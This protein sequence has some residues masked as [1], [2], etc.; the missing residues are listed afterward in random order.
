METTAKVVCCPAQSMDPIP[1]GS[2]DLVVTSPPYPMVEMW[3]GVFAAQDEGIG[4][5][6]SRGDGAAAFDLMHRLL[7]GAWA[8][9]ARVLKAGGIA[10][11]N[12]GDATRTI[13]GDFQLYSNHS[14]ILGSF[15]GKG[16]VALPDILWRKQTNAPTKF[17][18]SGMLPVGAYVTYEHEYVLVL[19]KGSR[20]TFASAAEKLRRRQSAFF[21]EERNVWFSDVWL[22][23]KGAGQGLV[24]A[25]ARERS[26]AFPFELAYRLICMFSIKGDVVL[27]PFA[28]TGTTLAAA[29]ATGRS[30]IG[31]ELDG[32]LVP[33]V[34]DYLQS[35]AESAN[36]YNRE[37]LD[38][39]VEWARSR[40]AGK[41]PL[42][43]TNRH[44]GFP[45]MT[46]QEQDLL[47]SDVTAVSGWSPDGT[48]TAR[49][50]EEPQPD[51]VQQGALGAPPA[52]T[53]R[54]DSPPLSTQTHLPL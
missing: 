26:A 12:I 22:D 50:S 39:H 28:G 35:V 54:Q 19:R 47:I 30:S 23:I 16:F 9:C 34:Q 38:R 49:Y 40:V 45:V 24:A 41:G 14:R 11:I 1:D 46:R 37:R 21:W 48:L 2:V 32:T 3:D 31:V 17:M 27:D 42:K 51:C 18:G 25:A 43:Y 44:Y 20:R 7:D 8:E 6:L 36:Q 52:P 5:C 4:A 10:C 13:D 15:L 33:V 53:A 29:L